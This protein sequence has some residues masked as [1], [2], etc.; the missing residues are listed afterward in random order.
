[1]GGKDGTIRE[2]IICPVDLIELIFPRSFREIDSSMAMALIA[3]KL[4]DIMV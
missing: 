3:K 2:R 1:M 4:G